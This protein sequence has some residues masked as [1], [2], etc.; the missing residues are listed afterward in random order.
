VT[1][2]ATLSYTALLTP[3]RPLSPGATF[4]GRAFKLDV[5]L[6][7]V[8]QPDFQFAQSIVLTIEYDP[9]MRPDQSGRALR[10]YRREGDSWQLAGNGYQFDDPDNHRIQVHVG[11]VGEYAL[12]DVAAEPYR[13]YL[14]FS[15]K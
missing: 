13:I 11:S 12:F 7:G 2:T 5:L 14:P 8:R 9:A 4:A 15:S 6:Q 1:R 3:T 10:L